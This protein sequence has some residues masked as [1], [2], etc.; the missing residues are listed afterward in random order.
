MD[1]AKS[2]KGQWPA[3]LETIL[4]LK[5]DDLLKQL[6]AIDAALL[7]SD[8]KARAIV[9][10]LTPLLSDSSADVRIKTI[11][12]LDKIRDPRSLT[13]LLEALGKGPTYDGAL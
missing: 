7:L 6:E 5:S 1:L 10:A 9:P 8:E 12:A 13:P 2:I 11:A 4:A 3:V